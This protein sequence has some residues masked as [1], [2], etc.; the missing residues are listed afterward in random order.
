MA[1][2]SECHGDSQQGQQSNGSGANIWQF[3]TSFL[4]GIVLAL[5]G[6]YFTANKDVVTKADLAVAISSQQRQLDDLTAQA[7]QQRAST[8][9]IEIDLGRIS[10]HLGVSPKK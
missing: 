8:V 3:L 5:I 2:A 9:Q 4:A 7:A 1:A 10:E 6:V